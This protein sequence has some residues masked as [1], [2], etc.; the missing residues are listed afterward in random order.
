ML[1]HVVARLDKARIA[2]KGVFGSAMGLVQVGSG[3]TR[4]KRGWRTER[5]TY[6]IEKEF[7]RTARTEAEVNQRVRGIPNG[8]A[9]MIDGDSRGGGT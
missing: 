2:V 3:Q 8:G 9:G 6:D 4:A 7:P 1:D 5:V